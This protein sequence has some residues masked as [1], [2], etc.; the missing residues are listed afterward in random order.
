MNTF[1]RL[2][3]LKKETEDIYASLVVETERLR[4]APSNKEG[5]YIKD[6]KTNNIIVKISEQ[7]AKTIVTF[8]KSI[9]ENI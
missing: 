7:E 2:A 6:R 3:Q 8:L 5:V 1:E 4:L 9:Y